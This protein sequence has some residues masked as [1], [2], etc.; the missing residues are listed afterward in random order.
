[1]QLNHSALSDDRLVV[2]MSGA[3]LLIIPVVPD[4]GRLARG[5]DR[6]SRRRRTEVA[7]IRLTG[8]TGADE[9]GAARR[10]RAAA[11]I[12]SSWQAL[13]ADQASSPSGLPGLT[14]VSITR[15]FFL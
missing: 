8:R 11:A 1:M 9:N 3:P 14:P 6:P 4:R 7:S 5:E 2:R 12:G 13:S 15:Y 10:V